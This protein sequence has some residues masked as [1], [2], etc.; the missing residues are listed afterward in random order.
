LVG[1]LGEFGGRM[2]VYAQ[3]WFVANFLYFLGIVWRLMPAALEGAGG[4]CKVLEL[5]TTYSNFNEEMF[6][7]GRIYFP[8]FIAYILIN[9]PIKHAIIFIRRIDCA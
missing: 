6:N 9:N 1:L 4:G 8:C 5:T 2:G 3:R 7:S